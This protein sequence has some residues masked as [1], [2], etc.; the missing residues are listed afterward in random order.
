[1]HTKKR[2]TILLASF[3]GLA[4]VF[5]LI[6]LFAAAPAQAQAPA[7][8]PS[9]EVV[10]TH[11]VPSLVRDLGGVV[12]GE[13]TQLGKL[14]CNTSNCSQKV[15]VEIYYGTYLTNL[16]SIEYKFATRLADN[17]EERTVVV[18]GSGS[19]TLDRMKERFRFT[20]TFHDNRD[21]TVK[22]TYEA[23]RPD[24]SFI[25]TSPGS[26]IIESRR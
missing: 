8:E 5:I 10:F 16:L 7:K 12:V 9:Y 11:A 18:D 25:I 26:F 1:V 14:M 19:I 24:A 23:S 6:G 2:T 3:L 22:A 4:A 17:P 20:A 13:G 15:E 21:G